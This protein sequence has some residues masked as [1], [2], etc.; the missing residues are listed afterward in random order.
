VLSELLAA[1]GVA[2]GALTLLMVVAGAYEP[3]REGLPLN[4][5]VKYVPLIIPYALPW[6]IPT[7]FVA[8]CIMV[9]SRMAGDN[10]LTAVRASGIHLWRTVTPAAG[11]AVLLCV[12]CAGLNHYLVPRT[13]FYRYNIAKTGSASEQAAAIRF[14][15]PVMRIGRQTVYMGEV[16]YDSFRNIVIVMP[17]KTLARPGETRGQ[18]QVTYFKAPQGHFEYSDEEGVITLYLESKPRPKDTTNRYFGQGEMY[19]VVH[20]AQ[21]LDFERAVF[22]GATVPIKVR[23]ANDLSFFPSKG[24][25]MTTSALILKANAR[26]EEIRLRLRKRPDTAGMSPERKKYEVKR[27]EKWNTEP[28][29]WRTQVHRRAA[30]SLAPLLL[31]A[32]AIPLGVRTRRGRRLVAFGLAIVLVLGGYYPLMAAGSKLGESGKLPPGLAVWAMTAV[33][34]GF[35]VALVS[36]MFRR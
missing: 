28:R 30:L 3:V 12:L 31:G 22:G 33:V 21:P 20:G 17:D 11:M 36:N 1:F 35:G 34:V 4:L 2:V 24:K 18:V 25:H 15:D 27:W 29:Y 10:E 5:L 19:K 23:S 7:A 26:E 9:Y 32:I 6:T 14:S 13:R 16:D 8:A